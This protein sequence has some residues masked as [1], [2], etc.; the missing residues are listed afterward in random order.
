MWIAARSEPKWARIDIASRLPSSTLVL[1]HV[2][3]H[4][5]IPSHLKHWRR[6]FQNIDF[7]YHNTSCAENCDALYNTPLTCVHS[8]SEARDRLVI[9]D[10]LQ[11]SLLLQ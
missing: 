4:T 10:S 9:R 8:E 1:L 6:Q 5:L 11:L 7:W 3:I 2:N